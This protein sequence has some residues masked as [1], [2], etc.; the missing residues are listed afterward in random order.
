ML[1]KR[2]CLHF[3][4]RV[5]VVFIVCRL[6]TWEPNQHRNRSLNLVAITVMLSSNNKSLDNSSD[7]WLVVSYDV[8]LK[9]RFHN[10]YGGKPWT[11]IA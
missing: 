8:E 10:F 1:E 2:L 6:G 5:T 7:F 9:S 11:I 3:F 4:S